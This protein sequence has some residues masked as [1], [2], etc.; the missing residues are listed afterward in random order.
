[1]RLKQ[2]RAGDPGIE[3][4]RCGRGFRYRWSDGR[5]VRDETILT[6]IRDLVL[7]PAWEDVWICAEAN[8]HLQASGIDS[9]GRRQY[10]Y[11]DAWTTS[12]GAAKHRRVLEFAAVLPKVRATTADHLAQRGFGRERV[13]AGAV[14]LLDLGFFRSGSA[15]YEKEHETFGLSTLRREHVH[16]GKGCVRFEFMAKGSQAQEQT[17]TEESVCRLVR[18][19]VRRK[20]DGPELLAWRDRHGWHDVTAADINGYLQ[21]ISGGPFTAKDFRTWH[22][23]VLAA[24][25]F[26]VSTN[27]PPTQTGQKRAV[28][29]VVKEVAEYLGDTPAVARRSYIDPRVIQA[30]GDGQTV[31]RALRKVG[32]DVAPG[33]LATNGP[34]EK[35]VA[36]MLR[37]LDGPG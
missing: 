23:T 5:P 33:E 36:R 2:T 17:V 30:Y 4:V 27:A 6:R 34:F 19:L 13:L 11:H 7:P 31:A 25:G 10:R 20:D 12:R 28:A 37:S 8:G 22:A 32:E 9:A 26:A 1:M 29:R 15:A 3:R 18:G 21:E 14:Q 35:A 16:V 24:A